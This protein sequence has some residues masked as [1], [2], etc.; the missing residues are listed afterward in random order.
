MRWALGLLVTAVL[1]GAPPAHGQS[2]SDL[3]EPNIGLAN[4]AMGHFDD[5]TSTNYSEWYL[6]G[7]LRISANLL[8]DDCWIDPTEEDHS[9]REGGALSRWTR[10]AAL[11]IGGIAASVEFVQDMVATYHYTVD[12]IESIVHGFDARRPEQTVLR[13]AST[14]MILD[15]R[16]DQAEELSLHHQ[17]PTPNERYGKIQTLVLRGLAYAQDAN[18][19]AVTLADQATNAQMR[20]D[21][22]GEVEIMEIGRSGPP[23]PN[24]GDPP[25]LPHDAD[26]AAS[27]LYRSPMALAA[28]NPFGDAGPARAAAAGAASAACVVEGDMSED[29]AVIYQRVAVMAQGAQM[30][31]IPTAA[32]IHEE[33]DFLNLVRV[34]ELQMDRE[35]FRLAT[36]GSFLSW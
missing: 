32:S 25:P 33:R 13:L 5:P 14:S 15:A 4:S 8:A 3:P 9:R 16:L 1:M 24:P 29:P 34:R 11:F 17:L 26:A 19:N 20:I 30:G 18:E 6:P 7:C 36:F 12:A 21:D 2:L 27:N 23:P 22:D 10:A 35:R 28:G 31:A